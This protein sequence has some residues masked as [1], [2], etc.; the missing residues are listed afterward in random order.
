MGLALRVYFSTPG[1]PQAHPNLLRQ[2]PGDYSIW[3][4]EEWSPFQAAEA[5][6][7][8]FLFGVGAVGGWLF[9]FGLPCCL[10]SS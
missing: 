3:A 7:L 10:L 4:T 5:K 6:E 8:P 1:S 9:G 2:D